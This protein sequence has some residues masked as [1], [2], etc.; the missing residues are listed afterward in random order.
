MESKAPKLVTV[1]MLISVLSLGVTPGFSQTDDENLQAALDRGYVVSGSY[2]S[3]CDASRRGGG[4]LGRLG[5][6]SSMGYHRRLM[7]CG[8]AGSIT[9][10][11]SRITA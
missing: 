10:S 2:A 7:S 5:H 4:F 6:L 8:G 1:V 3:D 9:S 11:S